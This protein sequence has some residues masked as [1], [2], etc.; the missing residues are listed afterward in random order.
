MALLIRLVTLIEQMVKEDN[1]Q[2]LCLL[3]IECI[4]SVNNYDR[5]SKQRSRY[6]MMCLEEAIGEVQLGLS[7]EHGTKLAEY[8]RRTLE[9]IEI[10]ERELKL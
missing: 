4:S 1:Y 5:A 6:R 7:T 3:I 2:M 10:L 8:R 9:G